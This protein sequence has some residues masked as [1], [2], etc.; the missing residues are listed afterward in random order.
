MPAVPA[1]APSHRR[2]LGGLRPDAS[3]TSATVV[4]PAYAAW[5]DGKDVPNG[6]TLAAAGRS[7]S[8]SSLIAFTPRGVAADPDVDR[9]GRVDLKARRVPLR[10]PW[11]A[12]DPPGRLQLGELDRLERIRDTCRGNAE[13]AGVQPRPAAPPVEMVELVGVVR[14]QDHV[15]GRHLSAVRAREP[16]VEWLRLAPE[17]V[18]K[19]RGRGPKLCI[20]V[21]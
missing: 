2:G 11:E 17:H 20:P 21:F 14:D 5:P 15:R 13:R 10:P 12:P 19:H 6:S 18:R 7:R 1:A 3:R 8:T 16:Q 9:P 4:A